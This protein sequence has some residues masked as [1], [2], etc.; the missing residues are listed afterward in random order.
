MPAKSQAALRYAPRRITFSKRSCTAGVNFAGRPGGVSLLMLRD[1]SIEF[2]LCPK[3][4][5]AKKKALPKKDTV[6]KKTLAGQNPRKWHP[7]TD[8]VP[9]R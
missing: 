9:L 4:D 6:R 7:E 3:E 1:G 8:R 5:T 2:G